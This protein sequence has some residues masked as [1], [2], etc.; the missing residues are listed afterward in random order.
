MDN[1]YP[2]VAHSHGTVVASEAKQSSALI[3]TWNI[4]GAHGAPY[5]L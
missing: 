4:I 2:V 5:G 3:Q 1:A